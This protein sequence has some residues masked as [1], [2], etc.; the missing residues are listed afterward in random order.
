LGYDETGLRTDPGTA[1]TG[2]SR[3]MAASTVCRDPP[4]SADSTTTTTSAK[5][6]MTRLR[7]G[8]LHGSG[9]APIGAS[10]S[11][12]P[13]PATSSHSDRCAGG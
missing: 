4:F 13:A 8:N 9:L 12:R 5:A 7:T 3:A 1:I 6:A 10:L 2:R 11:S